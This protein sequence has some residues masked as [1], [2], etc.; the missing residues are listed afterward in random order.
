[1]EPKLKLTEENP[2]TKTNCSLGLK[3]LYNPSY[4]A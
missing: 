4:F 2:A 1:M 3:I